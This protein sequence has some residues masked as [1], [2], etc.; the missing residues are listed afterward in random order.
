[1]ADNQNPSQWPRSDNSDSGAVRQNMFRSRA[2]LVGLAQSVLWI[3][4]GVAAIV[5]VPRFWHIYDEY[6]TCLPEITKAL[7]LCMIFLNHFWFLVLPLVLCWPF[8]NLGIVS[9]LSLWPGGR[10]RERLWYLAT[11]L[12]LLIAVVFAVVASFLPFV[13]PPPIH[14]SG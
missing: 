7:Q 13:L 14:L 11:W 5:L 2:F 3:T 10:V 1:M 6:K 9:L 12:V 8:I 4:L